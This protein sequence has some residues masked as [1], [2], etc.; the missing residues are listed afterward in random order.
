MRDAK[1]L[2]A[3]QLYASLGHEVIAVLFLRKAYGR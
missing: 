1:A 3:A 2:K